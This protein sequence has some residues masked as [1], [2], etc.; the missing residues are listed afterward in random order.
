MVL[1][2]TACAR[3]GSVPAALAREDSMRARLDV[4]IVPDEADAVVAILERRAAGI[5]PGEDHWQRLFASEGY[6]RLN[7]RERAFRRETSDSAFRAFVMSD[8]LIVRWVELRRTLR[9]WRRIDPFS[10]AIRA[11]EYL[12]EH[13]RIRARIYPVIKPRTNSFVW[14]TATNPAIF[15]YVDPAVS[16]VKFE[17]TLAHELHHIGV[18]AACR[19]RGADSSAAPGLRAALEWLTGFAEGRAVL[20]AAGGAD[21]H[22]H[23]ASDEAERAIWERDVARVPHDVQ[24]LESFFFELLDQRLAPE[25]RT[26]RGFGFIATDSVPQGAFYTV[27]WTMA[28]VVE[29]ELGRTALNASVC[30]PRLFIT[31]Y[32]RAVTRAR[33]A[34]R[35]ASLPTWSDSLIAR[36]GAPARTTSPASP[37]RR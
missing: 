6:R 17:N 8:T 34:G 28:S 7:D 20:A 4:Q 16:A 23:A 13:A 32:N 27:G 18:A 26:R 9:D 10:A 33:A 35:G 12:P 1:A 24:R 36:L 22:P 29:R 31:D 19:E 2:L 11:F 5:P 15:L 30:D 3:P 14:E 21:V 37:G 25:D